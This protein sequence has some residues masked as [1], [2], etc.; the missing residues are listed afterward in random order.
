MD[1]I[2]APAV[3][4]NCANCNHPTDQHDPRCP[5]LTQDEGWASRYDKMLSLERDS[6][7]KGAYQGTHRAPSFPTEPQPASIFD[8]PPA[9]REYAK[10]K[11]KALIAEFAGDDER[12]GH[13]LPFLTVISHDMSSCSS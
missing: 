12:A 13:G 10:A 3:A 5:T 2:P 1:H 6:R 11:A 4:G 9:D 8:A 7:A